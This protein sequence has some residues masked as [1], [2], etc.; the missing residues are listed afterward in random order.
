VRL[1]EDTHEAAKIPTVYSAVSIFG[2]I[3]YLHTVL[4]WYSSNSTKL[5]MYT[6]QRQQSGGYSAPGAMAFPGSRVG[7]GSR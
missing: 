1:F 6:A 2:Y 3:N 7:Q 5:L 4:T